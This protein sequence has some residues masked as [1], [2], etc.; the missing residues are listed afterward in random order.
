MNELTDEMILGS[1]IRSIGTPSFVPELLEYMRDVATFRGVMIA[2]L[3][4]APQGAI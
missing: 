2:I 3:R 4:K 1:T